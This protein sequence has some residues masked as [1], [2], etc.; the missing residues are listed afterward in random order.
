MDG[1]STSKATTSHD[2][3][4]RLVKGRSPNGMAHTLQQCMCQNARCKQVP[5]AALNIQA[6]RRKFSDWSRKF[7]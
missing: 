7:S 6:G 5:R 4:P 2:F 3:D 1:A